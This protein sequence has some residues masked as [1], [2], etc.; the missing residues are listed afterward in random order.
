VEFNLTAL[1]FKFKSINSNPFNS[2][3][4]SMKVSP[5]AIYK[6]TL[7]WAFAESGL[8][9]LLH[10]FKLPVTGFVLGA[11][12]VIIISLIAYFSRTPY[13]DILQATLVVLAIKF[14]VSPHSPLPAYVA[15]LFQGFL[16]AC[17][18]Q[19]VGHRLVTVLFFSILVLFESAI[20]K[21]LVATLLFGTELWTAIDA[22]LKQL[23]SFVGIKE[24][25]HAS[26][27]FLVTYSSL[28][29]L[30]GAFIG[31]WAYR[32]PRHLQSLHVD[33]E[34]L[35]QSI[36]GSIN[37]SKKSKIRWLF[38]AMLSLIVVSLFLYLIQSVNPWWY[39]FRTSIIIFGVYVFLMPS[40][41]WLLQRF[42][43]TQKSFIED[44][45]K[46]L[47]QLKLTVQQA[48]A[49]SSVERNYWK[50][51]TSFVLYL[52]FLNSIEDEEQV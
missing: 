42:S 17:L 16:G 10:G 6:L 25:N 29:I 40:I 49:L 45:L 7:L 23:L 3:P 24:V 14:A 35:K 33:R 2:I 4:F 1:T 9:G 30:W 8:G 36:I 5:Q 22:L 37:V 43:A 27:L 50:R 38:F 47:P 41:R 11:F 19:F 13:R 34:I 32:L 46:Q 31:M 39:L 28:Y 48:S 15:V 44:Y 52:L 20:Q 21:P 51:I 26:W 18:F 12:S